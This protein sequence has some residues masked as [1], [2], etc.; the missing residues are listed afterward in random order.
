MLAYPQVSEQ[1]Y[2]EVDARD[3]AVGGILSQ[4]NESGEL[5]PVAYYSSTL[6]RSQKNWSPHTKEAYAVLM[7]VMQW[8]V[9]LVGSEFTFKSDHN[10]LVQLRNPKNPKGKFAR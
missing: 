3:Y 6:N 7:A 2:V 9:Y 1:F 8:H 10:P 4:E 5:H